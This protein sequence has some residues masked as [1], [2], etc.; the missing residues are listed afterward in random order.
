[1]RTKP[2][3][4]SAHG[5]WSTL[6]PNKDPT[7]P[8]PSSLNFEALTQTPHI[9]QDDLAQ[10]VFFTTRL[11]QFGLCSKW[12]RSGDQIVIFD[13]LWKPFTLRP[14]INE[15]RRHAWKLV[16]DCFVGE[17]TEEAAGGGPTLSLDSEGCQDEK[18]T[19]Y[20]LSLLD[21]RGERRKRR[22]WRRQ[23]VLD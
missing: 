22:L 19:E 1:M 21:R 4:I 14:T 12:A 3:S 13:G 15:A 16:G 2:H 8:Y 9:R 7:V 10:R 6:H 11:G 18:D 20:M 23:F 17:C 5:F